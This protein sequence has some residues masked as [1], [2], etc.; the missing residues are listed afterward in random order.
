MLTIRAELGRIAVALLKKYER[1]V[2]LRKGDATTPVTCLTPWPA[3]KCL[4]LMPA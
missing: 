4:V 1:D 3:A 2:A